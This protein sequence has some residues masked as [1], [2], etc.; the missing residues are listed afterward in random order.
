VCV[1]ERKQYIK[2]EIEG[3]S[4]ELEKLNYHSFSLDTIQCYIFFI[5]KRKDTVRS[6][7][8]EIKKPIFIV[9]VT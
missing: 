7:E 3:K 1:R 4:K 6:E 8:F 9:I 2:E 5:L